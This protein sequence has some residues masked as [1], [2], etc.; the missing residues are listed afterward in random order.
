MS[1]PYYIAFNFS[2][3]PIIP[4]REILIAQLSSLGFESFV[5]TVN[6]VEAYIKNSDYKPTILDDIQI[7][8]NNSFSIS[9][10]VSNQAYFLA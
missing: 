5:E 2:V 7:L 4:G 3:S 6:G 8:S 9:Y 1:N 10:K